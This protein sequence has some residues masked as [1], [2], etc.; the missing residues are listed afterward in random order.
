MF[1]DI[2]E[3]KTKKN[4]Q[5]KLFLKYGLRFLEIGLFVHK[6]TFRNK[7]KITVAEP[8]KTEDMYARLKTHLGKKF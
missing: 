1:L 3:F 2:L 8:L 7:C 5:G 4:R 6:T